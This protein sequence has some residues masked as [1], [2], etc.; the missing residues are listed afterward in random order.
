[1]INYESFI[2]SFTVSSQVP[3]GELILMS[4]QIYLGV[5]ALGFLIGNMLYAVH[6]W[7]HAPKFDALRVKYKASHFRTEPKRRKTLKILFFLFACILAV[8]MTVF[9]INRILIILAA[10]IFM[11]AS[12]IILSPLLRKYPRLV[13][14]TFLSLRKEKCSLKTWLRY[15]FLWGVAYIG[16]GYVCVLGYFFA[17]FAFI[18]IYALSSLIPA[19]DIIS[20]YVQTCQVCIAGGFFLGNVLYAKHCVKLNLARKKQ[21]RGNYKETG[22]KGELL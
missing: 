16:F 22:R 5:I 19:G 6:C 8:F 14:K 7:K 2:L 12:A 3:A 13:L 9:N 4:I 1:M 18:D 11:L 20:I 17:F 15:S 21:Y 10:Y